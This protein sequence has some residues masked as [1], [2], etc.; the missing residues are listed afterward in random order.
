M[1]YHRRY[2]LMAGI[3]LGLLYDIIYGK[4]IGIH[5]GGLAAIGYLSGWLMYFF[6]PSFL[7]FV[8]IE[9]ISLFTYEIY[10]YGLHRLF[11]LFSSPFQWTFINYLLPTLV[12]NLVVSILSFKLLKQW[13]IKEDEEENA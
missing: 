2:G 9:G 13:F 3:L 5:M 8:I 1:F 12:F 4:G 10:L 11:Q 6:Q 7:I